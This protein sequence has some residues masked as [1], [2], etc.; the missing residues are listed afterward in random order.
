MIPLKI[1]N[2]LRLGRPVAAEL[3]RSEPEYRAW[4][5]VQPLFDPDRTSFN[6]PE[7]G[8]ER[9]VERYSEG[10]LKGYRVRYVRVHEK[11]LPYPND[12]DLA[13]EDSETSSDVVQVSNDEE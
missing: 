13:W 2:R 10:N 5:H 4:I 8:L 6:D 7:F 11:Y 3:P 9:R 1:L 12:L